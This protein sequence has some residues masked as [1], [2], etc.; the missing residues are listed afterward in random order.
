M[1]G[2]QRCMLCGWWSTKARVI[3]WWLSANFAPAQLFVLATCTWLHRDGAGVKCV[4]C[5]A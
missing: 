4:P 3:W 2:G 1:G 5:C